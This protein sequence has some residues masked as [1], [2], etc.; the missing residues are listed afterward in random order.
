MIKGETPVKER[1]RLFEAFRAGEVGLLVVSKVANFSID[2]P[3]AEVAIQVSGL[4]RLPPGGGPAAGP[5]PPP[6]GR[7][8]DRALLHDR[9]P[10][11]RRRRVRPAPPAV[12][13]R[14]GLRLP[15]RRRGGPADLMDPLTSPP[16]RTERLTLRLM[17]PADADAVASTRATRGVPLPALRAPQRDELTEKLTSGGRAAGP[18]VLA[19]GRLLA[20]RRREG[21]RVVGEIFF[22]LRSLANRPLRSAGCSTRPRLVRVR[23]RG[24]RGDAGPRVRR[25]RPASGHRAARPAN[26]RSVAL[27]RRL[28]M[29]H[30]ALFRQDEWIKGAWV[31]TLSSL[32]RRVAGRA[33]SVRAISESA[34]M[35]Y[36]ARS[37]P[38]SRSTRW[39]ASRPGEPMT[40]PPGWVPEPHW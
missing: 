5:D 28:G 39:L 13:R 30:E 16:L 29:R 26:E 31:D 32:R 15:D 37:R 20:D 40:Q 8:Q 21:G 38:R 33:S 1:Q 3:S 7:G 18:G 27:C 23:D 22:A 2:L 24:G 12:P 6:Q 35:T 9:L 34:V 36:G 10:R 4:V 19:R 17:T 14:A 11:H 25:A